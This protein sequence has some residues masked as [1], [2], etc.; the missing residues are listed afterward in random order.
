MNY[1]FSENSLPCHCMVLDVR[2]PLYKTTGV[3]FGKIVDLS[4][5]DDF[6]LRKGKIVLRINKFSQ[7]EITAVA[8]RQAPRRCLEAPPSRWGRQHCGKEPA[9]RNPVG[10][11]HHRHIYTGGDHPASGCAVGIVLPPHS[12]RSAVG[13]GCTHRN[14]RR[15]Y[16]VFGHIMSILQE[17]RSHRLLSRQA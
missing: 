2:P 14:C 17:K 12:G 3:G 16:F 13:T 15:S 4:V 11:L 7:S 1:Y 9:W 8:L 5:R 6:P 10:V